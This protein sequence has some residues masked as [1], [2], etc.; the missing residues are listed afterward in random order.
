MRLQEAERARHSSRE[1]YTGYALAGLGAAFFSTKAIFIKLAYQERVDAGLMLAYR[2]VFALP[3][4]VAIGVWAY[5]KRRAKGEPNPDT[6]SVALAAFTGAIGYYVAS[7]FD[8]AGLQ[9]IS[10]ALERLVLFTYPLFVMFLAAA[11]LREPI[12]RFGWAAAV[13]T[14]L[15]LAIVFGADLPDGGRSTVIGT[16]LVLGAAIS[17]A[18]HQ[19]LAK[20]FIAPLGSALFTSIA[21]TSASVLCILHQAVVSGDFSASP[22]FLWLALGC[23]VVATVLPTFMINAGIQRTSPQAVS[24]ISTLSPIVTIGLAI[25]ILG[26]P[27]T[28]ADAIGSSLVV[29]GV[30]L[31]TWGDSRKSGRRLG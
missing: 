26:E 16:L 28:L 14:Y 12:T 11:F 19:I 18:V 27:F 21:L 5:M 1:R 13:V 15:G 30:G 4:F 31:F 10:A 24:M 9:Y 17:F 7:A 6:R 23:A 20:K 25:A 3:I 8:F 29:A 2:M 22:R